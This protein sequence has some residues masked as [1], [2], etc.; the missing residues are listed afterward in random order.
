MTIAPRRVLVVSGP[1]L[2][3][4]GTRQPN[5]Y[6]TT[7]LDAIHARL[8]EVARAQRAE[9]TCRQTNHEG[10]IVSWIGAAPAEGFV[11][12][13]INAGAYT[14]TSLAIADAISAVDLPA[15]EVHL[16][17]IHA[18]EAFRRRSRIAP[19]CIG[20][21]SGFGALS[22]QLGLIALLS[23]FDAAR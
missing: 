10:E 6:G 13:V 1:N 7:T 18:R 17:N 16:T 21:I 19:A 20:Q 2:Q 3:L 23:R 5:L 15:V 8:D 9:V 22:Y 4:L 12:M 14:H 11:G